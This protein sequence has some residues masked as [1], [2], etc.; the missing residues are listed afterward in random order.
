MIDHAPSLARRFTD[1]CSPAAGS[2]TI[3]AVI[4][5]RIRVALP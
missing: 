4:I 2:A 5:M 3:L 1:L